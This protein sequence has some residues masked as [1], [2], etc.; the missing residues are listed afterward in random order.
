MD[1]LLQTKL[2]LES[3]QKYLSQLITLGS[4]KNREIREILLIEN[5]K[6]LSHINNLLFD[7]CNHEWITD[8]IFN[9]LDDTV[10]KI[11]YCNICGLPYKKFSPIN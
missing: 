7:E 8:E 2:I 6:E 1:Q 10:T 3:E 11:R 9:S 4:I 5:R